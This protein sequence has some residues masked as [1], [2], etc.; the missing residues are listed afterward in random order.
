MKIGIF[1]GKKQNY[2]YQILKLLVEN[3]PMTAWQLAKS[4]AEV[5]RKGPRTTHIIYATLIRKTNPIGRLNELLDKGYITLLENKRYC[6]T[7]KGIIAYI[8]S[9]ERPKISDFYKDLSSKIEIPE[10]F[11]FRLFDLPKDRIQKYIDEFKSLSM[12]ELS[13]LKSFIE[14]SIFWID[15]DAITDIELVIILVLRLNVTLSR[16][17]LNLLSKFGKNEGS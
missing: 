16:E 15:L 11:E 13:Y 5:E 8:L 10:N 14:K 6:P 1:E 4:I 12:E 9:E 3:E 17:V 2:N 7:F